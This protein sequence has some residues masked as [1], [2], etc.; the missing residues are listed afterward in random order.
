M[1]GR[2]GRTI[3]FCQKETSERRLIQSREETEA[4]NHTK[5]KKK[6]KPGKNEKK[7]KM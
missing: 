5:A 4:E 3:S 1:R 6:E 7:A 2:C